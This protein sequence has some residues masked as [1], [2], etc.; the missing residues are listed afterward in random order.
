MSENSTPGSAADRLLAFQALVK[1]RNATAIQQV[2]QQQMAYGDL[3]DADG[4]DI[5]TDDD[6]RL[7]VLEH[8]NHALRV[9]MASLLDAV[10]TQ[11]TA[12]VEDRFYQHLDRIE[13]HMVGFLLE[14]DGKPPIRAKHGKR[15]ALL[16]RCLRGS[17]YSDGKGLSSLVPPALKNLAGAVPAK[18][19]GMSKANLLSLFQDVGFSTGTMD[20]AA[21]DAIDALMRASHAGSTGAIGSPAEFPDAYRGR[22]SLPEFHALLRLERL[23]NMRRE[24]SLSE[25]ERIYLAWIVRRHQPLHAQAA[26]VLAVLTAM[27]GDMLP[28]RRNLASLDDTAFGRFVMAYKHLAPPSLERDV[29]AFTVMGDAP[30]A[31]AT[32]AMPI[33]PLGDLATRATAWQETVRAMKLSHMFQL[34]SLQIPE[35]DEALRVVSAV[36]S[37]GT[38]TC[39]SCSLDHSQMLAELVLVHLLRPRVP[40]AEVVLATSVLAKVGLPWLPPATNRIPVHIPGVAAEIVMC[41][42]G[43]GHQQMPI[44]DVMTSVFTAS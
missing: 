9:H 36:S 21:W 10:T 14:R 27:L 31:L 22:H 29:E 16:D 44:G 43:V 1:T 32:S 28:S 2:V 17:E 5:S 37:T 13:G 40:I 42:A 39:I 7:Q 8:L 41:A 35:I 15:L 20:T 38:P 33:P 19:G 3:A 18:K 11:G 25:A 4:R 26:T 24:V 23:A 30:R 34:P 12:G 6:P